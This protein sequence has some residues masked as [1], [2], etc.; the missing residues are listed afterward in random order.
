MI[1][2]GED[3]ENFREEFCL[4]LA[5]NAGVGSELRRLRVLELDTHVLELLNNQQKCTRTLL[6]HQRN[7]EHHTEEIEESKQISRIKKNMRLA[8]NTKLNQTSSNEAA[9]CDPLSPNVTVRRLSPQGSHTSPQVS[10]VKLD[11]CVGRMRRRM[12]PQKSQDS[13][14]WDDDSTQPGAYYRGFVSSDM[15]DT[16]SRKDLDPALWSP[17]GTPCTKSPDNSSIKTQTSS[18]KKKA[19]GWRKKLRLSRSNDNSTDDKTEGATATQDKPKSPKTKNRWSSFRSNH[20]QKSKEKKE[21]KKAQAAA[22]VAAAGET[23]KKKPSKKKMAS[24]DEDGQREDGKPHNRQL[25]ELELSEG[26]LVR[27]ASFP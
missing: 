1:E 3:V 24:Q 9:V 17:H 22:A 25:E 10:Q 8:S 14:D 20:K 7:Q 15:E 27:N 11:E 18:Q 2:E 13:S 21:K 12:Q 16:D 19:K 5:E 23:A 26:M 6:L 4:V